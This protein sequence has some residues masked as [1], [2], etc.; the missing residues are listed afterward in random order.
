MQIAAHKV[1]TIDY[2]LTDDAG[3]VIDS[4]EG[5]EP[6]AYIQ[7]IG[8]II[9]GLEAALEGKK[10]GDSLK[11]SIAPAEGYGERD[12]SLKQAVPRQMFETPEEIQVGMQFHTM[13]E[14]GNVMVVTVVET[15]AE[16]VTVDANHPLA[17]QNLNFDV[18][19]KDVREATSEELEHGHVH[20]AGGHHH[21]H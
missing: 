6:L 15:S 11:V 5:G 16:T 19:V 9:P 2:T 13:T 20:G 17:G 1:V 10:A 18:T 7:G 21:D 4:S 12:D 8:N 3:Q 14:D